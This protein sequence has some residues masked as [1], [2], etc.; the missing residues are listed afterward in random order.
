MAE[1][2][3]PCV[4]KL[5]E[6][7]SVENITTET[8][9]Q[10][11]H[12]INWDASWPHS[13]PVLAEAL[14]YGCRWPFK[15]G[16]AAGG[17]LLHLLEVSS[18]WGLPDRQN[19]NEPGDPSSASFPSPAVTQV[20][21]I[22]S[23]HSFTAFLSSITLLCNWPCQK[24]P[25]ITTA[26]P[27]TRLETHAC[28]PSLSTAISCTWMESTLLQEILKIKKTLLQASGTH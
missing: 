27:G 11:L 20:L 6:D 5:G 24:S 15:A 17:F 10:R 8:G 9:F 26:T 19:H 7:L 23:P 12:L 21:Q 4:L 25:Y 18:I 22:P 3:V 1:L 13:S 28:L 2:V 14:P 16:A